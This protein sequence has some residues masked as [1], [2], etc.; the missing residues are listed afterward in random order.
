MSETM[1][2]IG[3]LIRQRRPSYLVTANL[4]FAFQASRDIELH[5]ILVEAELVLCD[6]TPMVWLSRLTGAPLRERVA[7][8]DLIPKLAE[9]SAIEGWRI[10][11]LGGDP[12]Y[13]KA[14]TENMLQK[15][16]GIVISG[17]YSPPFA[18]IDKYNHADISERIKLAA[19]DI[20]LV[21]FGCPKQEKWI[22]RHYRELGVPCCIG[23]GAT[24]DFLGG[25]VRRAPGWVGK[26]GLE[27]IVR[28]AQE[29]RRLMGRYLK[30]IH[31]LVTQ[32]IKERKMLHLHCSK[33]AR[34][35]IDETIRQDGVELLAWEGPVISNTISELASPTFSKPFIMDLSKVTLIDS[36]GLGLVLGVIRN[37]RARGI[38]GCFVSPSGDVISYLKITRLERVL[39]VAATLPDALEIINRS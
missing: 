28:L 8:S 17:T 22:Y 18:P 9:R 29:P 15:Y 12:K 27:W 21:A 24:I 4:D 30:D 5:R 36:S 31:F 19:P 14:A 32:Y 7:G 26:M 39:P 20:L 38:H 1:D 34:S 11:L 10:F 23:V 33:D 25:K 3:H 13:L 35:T 2:W 16:P 37:A 6:G